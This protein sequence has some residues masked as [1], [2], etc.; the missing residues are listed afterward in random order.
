M[1][2]VVMKKLK[3]SIPFLILLIT[4][5]CSSINTAT[6]KEVPASQI[7]VSTLTP[8]PI[9]PTNTRVVVPTPT[10]TATP[11][12]PPI[13]T[14]A[15]VVLMKYPTNNS[16]KIRIDTRKWEI[17][18]QWKNSIVGEAV[19]ISFK[20]GMADAFFIKHRVY[21]GCDMAWATNSGFEGMDIKTSSKKINDKTWGIWSIE[22]DLIRLYFW[23]DSRDI[24]FLQK[25]PL[26][27]SQKDSCHSDVY[28]VLG[29]LQ[30][31][32]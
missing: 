26:D 22:N 21:I 28:E 12:Q 11:T 3:F 4:I 25:P 30:C 29:S 23:T 14:M 19:P 2:K 17:T 20:T 5:S 15:S 8:L 31:E 10:I 9:T 18:D 16:C 24:H 27:N 7:P 6:P 13:P 32:K 1:M